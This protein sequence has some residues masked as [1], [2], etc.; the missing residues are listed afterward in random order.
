MEFQKI[1]KDKSNREFQYKIQNQIQSCKPKLDLS[2][3]PSEAHLAQRIMLFSPSELPT[4][5]NL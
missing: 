5:K 4:S 3:L 1:K 2:H